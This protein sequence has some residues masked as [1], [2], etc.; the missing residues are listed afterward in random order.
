MKKALKLSDVE[1]VV[2]RHYQVTPE[3]LKL[4]T[5]IKEVAAPRQVAF[6]LSREYTKARNI[7]IAHYYN[8]LNTSTVTHAANR[9]LMFLDVYSNFRA[10]I[11]AMQKELD[12]QISL[13]ALFT[14]EA[15]MAEVARQV[16][17]HLMNKIK[18]ND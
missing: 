13:S 16:I 7:D 9:V 12:A 2:C 17:K 15:I 11:E 3:F 4:D 5:K 6:Y 14:K 8:R 18:R 10:D 1:R